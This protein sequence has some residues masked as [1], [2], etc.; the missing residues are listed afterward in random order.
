MEAKRSFPCK[1]SYKLLQRA[2]ANLK[3]LC[4][5]STM[6]FISHAQAKNYI[7]GEMWIGCKVLI[8]NKFSIVAIL[9][10]LEV[11]S[12]VV[13]ASGKGRWSFLLA[14]F[15]IAAI[16]FT[17]TIYGAYSMNER[18]TSDR[19]GNLLI[20]VEVV[21]CSV[22]FMLTG[23][24]FLLTTLG[25]KISINASIFPLVFAILVCFFAFFE[26]GF[27]PTTEATTSADNSEADTNSSLI[28]IVHS[29]DDQTEK[30]TNS[31]PNA[32]TILNHEMLQKILTLPPP[33][34]APPPRH[35]SLT[36]LELRRYNTM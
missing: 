25:V 34:P 20:I 26:E 31:T 3:Q 30:A 15:V 36:Q 17:I 7:L 27:N 23:I 9:V 13:E 11:I 5:L 14:S 6:R 19:S 1:A 8:N 2:F 35:G 21:F 4:L 24:Y 10:L 32:K 33:P 12:F 28:I 22:Q 16:G 18:P 29:P